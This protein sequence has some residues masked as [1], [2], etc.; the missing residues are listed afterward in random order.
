MP[1]LIHVVLVVVASWALAARPVGAAEP[2]G[3]YY[4]GGVPNPGAYALQ[5]NKVNLLQALIAARFDLEANQGKTIHLIRRDGSGKETVRHFGVADLLNKRNDPNSDTLLQP[6]DVVIVRSAPPEPTA[7]PRLQNDELAEQAEEVEE[8][9]GGLM[10]SLAAALTDERLEDARAA[11]KGVMADIGDLHK[12]APDASPDARRVHAKEAAFR[13]GL[14]RV[15]LALDAGDLV[16]ARAIA[17]GGFHVNADE[18]PTP[19][20]MTRGRNAQEAVKNIL[21][22]GDK[23]LRQRTLDSLLARLQGNNVDAIATALAAL[24]GVREIPFDRAPFLKAARE[25]LTHE[26]AD[27]RA[28]AVT[29]VGALGGDKGDVPKVAALAKDPVPAVRARVASALYAIAGAQ[30]GE[31]VLAAVDALLDDYSAPVQLNT[32][33]AL[34]GRPV[35]PASEA[36]LIALS[37]GS[38]HG[39]PGALAYDAVYYALST[40]PLVSPL[41]ADRLI[42]ILR[43][44]TGTE[45]AG[46]ASWGLSHHAVAPEAREKVTQAF[47]QELDET[48]DA[49]V[50][51]NIVYG[52]GALGGEPAVAK[53]KEL[54]EKDENERIRQEAAE[55]LRRAGGG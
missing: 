39:G 8:A 7:T 17:F 38:S 5:G 16:T 47:I 32:I 15:K 26:N 11:M 27:V 2:G 6:D 53:L 43:D 21:Q 30:P 18:P 40:R 49:Y 31:E 20:A 14:R 3:T 4:V 55:A 23:D 10:K 25:M 51:S 37:R 13:E 12:L 24:P 52:L 33:R 41:V 1:K 48:L 50:R 42:E 35:S 19:D 34:W 29:A 9:F 44:D 22:R 28:G 46:R 45:Q 54:A 36:K